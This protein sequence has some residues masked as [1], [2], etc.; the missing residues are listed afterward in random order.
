MQ[1]VS[2]VLALSALALAVPAFAQTSEEDYR[3][4]VAARL[5]GMPEEALQRLARA[6]AV[7]P[8]NADIHLQT[9]LALLA[10]GRLDEA[11]AAFRRTLELAPAY[12]D[13]RLGLARVAQRR[14][15]PT[16]ALAELDRVG[17]GREEADQL[18]RQIEAGAATEGWRWRVDADGSYSQVQ[19]QPDWQSAA[20]AVQ[21]RADANTIVVATLD[22]TRRFDRT[23]V[24]GEARADHRFAPGSNVYVLVGGAPDADFRPRWQLGAGVAARV[25]GGPYATVLRLDLRQADYPAGD[26]RIATPGVEQ[27]LTGRVWITGQWINV[28]DQFAHSSGWMV[29]GD[30]MPT[31]RLRLFAGA[32]DAPDLDAGVVIRTASVFGGVSADLGD[33]LTLRLSLAHENPEGPNDRD[34]VALGMGYRF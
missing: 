6:A 17:P 10:L 26:V 16:T 30:V 27:Y 3:A 7:Q 12:A 28:W 11:E 13:A 9:G 19:G 31:E 5:A 4:G 2:P 8:E 29:R 33:R 21:H 24:Y 20:L 22:T 32:A 15:D 14:N 23:D 34:T 1:P 18:R 25:H